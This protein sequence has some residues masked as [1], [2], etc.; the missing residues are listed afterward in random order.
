MA[1]GR[2][3]TFCTNFKPRVRGDGEE[4]PCARE[5]LLQ[6]GGAVPWIWIRI[7]VMFCIRGAGEEL[8]CAREHLI[9]V[10]GAGVDLDLAIDLGLDIASGTSV[11]RM[12]HLLHSD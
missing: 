3:S 2:Q 10:G 11:L 4:L 5:H 1:L 7:W 6:V 12:G 8:P 9:Q